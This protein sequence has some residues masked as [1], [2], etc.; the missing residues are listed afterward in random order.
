[1]P[2]EGLV[3]VVARSRQSA[4]HVAGIGALRSWAVGSRRRF[5]GVGGAD[6]PRAVDRLAAEVVVLMASLQSP[7]ETRDRPSAWT[8]AMAHCGPALTLPLQ[9]SLA[10][11]I[12]AVTAGTG[13]L[14][15]NACL[16]DLVNPLL[17]AARVP[18]LT[19]V[20]NVGVL[21]L[22]AAEALQVPASSLTVL[23]NHIHLD[24]PPEGVGEA[25]LWTAD[26]VPVDAGTAL[27]AVRS[28]PRWSRNPLTGLVSAQVVA[29]L[30][31]GRPLDAA[32]PGPHGLPG[33]YSIRIRD[34]ELE[35]IPPPGWPLERC[36]ALN[37]EWNRA[38]GVRIRNGSVEYTEPVQP[39]L[40]RVAPGLEAGFRIKDTARIAAEL[41]KLR[42]ALRREE[43]EG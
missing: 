1:M 10:L 18:V 27:A 28:L 26:G 20:G 5:V 6:L 33:G 22:G 7:W 8:R 35:P 4:E 3:S 19:G 29:A 39:V 43:E 34:R 2:G 12:G 11:E 40:A 41:L 32:A 21:A 15:V 25:L 30:A 42:Q 13:G 16:P 38:D 31:H 23:G 17:S 37:E 24:Q 36:V 9:A 14:F